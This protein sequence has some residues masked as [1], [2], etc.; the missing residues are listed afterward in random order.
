MMRKVDGDDFLGAFEKAIHENHTDEEYAALEARMTQL[1]RVFHDVG[2]V[3]QGD[4]ITLDYSGSRTVVSVNGKV[5]ARIKGKDFY[6]A[7]L[8]IWLGDNPVSDSL[9]RGLL[10]G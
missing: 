1:A 4:V 10:G 5:Q 7:L 8:K 6:Q 9:K 3:K 2:Q